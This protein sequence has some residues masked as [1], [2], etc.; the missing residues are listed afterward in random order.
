MRLRLEKLKMIADKLEKNLITTL[1]LLGV[2]QL[3]IPKMKK[4]I[5]R[6]YYGRLLKTEDQ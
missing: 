5:I 6:E 4:S 2:Y 1:G 3:I